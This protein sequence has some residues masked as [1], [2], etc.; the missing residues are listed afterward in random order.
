MKTV[1]I[2]KDVLKVVVTEMGKTEM[3][4]LLDTKS[5]I[6]IAHISALNLYDSGEIVVRKGDS[7]DAF[8][9]IIKGEVAILLPAE[10]EGDVVELARINPYNI[11]GSAGRRRR[12]RPSR[13]APG[14]CSFETS[15]S[16][17]RSPAAP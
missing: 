8:F 12:R 5:L 7:S 9:I 13:R 16:S 1:K 11:I 4:G 17:A 15:R 6:Q 10:G 14:I 3:F 2:E